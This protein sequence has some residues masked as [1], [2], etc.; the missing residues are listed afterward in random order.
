MKSLVRYTLAALSLTLAACGGNFAPGIVTV[1]G[2]ATNGL[3]IGETTA[4]T[5]SFKDGSGAAVAGKT[6]TWTSSAPDIAA[7][8]SS[9]QVTAKRF[10]TVTITATADGISGASAVQ[11]TYGLEV[12]G[13]T[14]D[15]TTFISGGRLGLAVLFRVRGLNASDIPA[16]TPFTIVYSG[17]NA[18][19]GGASVSRG[20]WQTGA[21]GVSFWDE[22]APTKTVVSGTYQASTSLTIAGVTTAYTTSFTV[23]TAQTQPRATAITQVSATTTDVSASWTAASG[24]GYYRI[25]VVDTSGTQ[26][27]NAFTSSVNAVL[28]GLSLNKSLTNYVIV[29]AMNFNY[30]SGLATVAPAQFNIGYDYKQLTIP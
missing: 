2:L 1:S 28:S 21:G 13:G 29:G 11:T 30:T 14:S 4:F 25:Y 12:V 17:P 27:K 6:F 19:N 8:D 7:V 18:W 10:G 5:A 9:G 26:T 23:D 16:A 15:T 22:P 20:V 24:A 3:K